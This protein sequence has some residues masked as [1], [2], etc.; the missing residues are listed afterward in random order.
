MEKTKP[1]ISKY[2]ADFLS[3]PLKLLKKAINIKTI[4]IDTHG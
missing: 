1:A 4:P 2:K 3:F